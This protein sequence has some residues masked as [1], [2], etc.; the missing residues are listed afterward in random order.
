MKYMENLYTVKRDDI[1][2]GRVIG[3]F[4]IGENSYNLLGKE[5]K[6]GAFYKYR[7][8]LF[9]KN[10]DNT[11]EDLLYDSP[12]YPIYTPDNIEACKNSKIIIDQA[13]NLSRLLRYYKYDEDLTF[14]DIERIRKRFFDGK[15]PI[16]NADK[17]GLIEID[18]ALQTY[19][20]NL[21]KVITDPDELKVLIKQRRRQI[22]LGGH[23]EF[24]FDE[25]LNMVPYEMLVTMIL[26]HE[27]FE[28]L[29]DCGNHSLY[30][31]MNGYEE[32][33]NAFKPHKEEGL[34]RSLK[35]YN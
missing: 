5:V 15:F 11:A 34:I 7:S 25:E 27:L 35:K 29:R 22:A 1:Y 9:V 4:E 10:M 6:L 21:G 3:E 26:P 16:E 17:F 20:N 13:Y 12:Q 31:V 23:R 30:D 8:M 33:I 32:R 24:T 18:P 28:V 14:L 2:V 19:Y